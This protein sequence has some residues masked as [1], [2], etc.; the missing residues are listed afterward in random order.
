MAL[1]LKIDINGERSTK[2]RFPMNYTVQETLKDIWTSKI[3]K[4]EKD[5][6]L[7]LPKEGNRKGKAMWLKT[8]RTLRY[9]DLHDGDTIVYK[10]KHR[11]FRY[12]LVDGSQ[13]SVLIDDSDEVDKICQ[14]IAEHI[15]LKN[16]LE[17]GLRYLGDKTGWL[18]KNLTLHAQDVSEDPLLVLLFAREFFGEPLD[19]NDPFQLQ[20]NYVQATNA[21]VEGDYPCTRK[22]AVLFAAL[23][24]QVTFGNHD[25]QKHVVGWLPKDTFLPLKWRK[26]KAIEE[27]II[28]EHKKLYGMNAQA[29]KYRYYQAMR[30]LRSFGISFF[31]GKEIYQI[32]DK[33]NKGKQKTKNRDIKLGVSRYEIVL[34]EAETNEFIHQFDLEKLKAYYPLQGVL[35]LD[36]GDHY[37][38]IITISTESKAYA[39]RVVQLISGYIDLI[40][41]VRQDVAKKVEDDDDDLAA[42]EEQDA[43]WM[44]PQQAAVTGS[45][46]GYAQPGM[47][48]MPYGFLPRS[49]QVKVVD[50]NSAMKATKFLANELGTKKANWQNKGNLS[51]EQAQNQFMNDKKALAA[52]V[53]EL[54]AAVRL[55]PRGI[56]RHDMDIRAQQLASQ[57]LSIGAG[58]RALAEFDGSPIL[59]GAKAVA[60]ALVDMLNLVNHVLEH[61]DDIGSI[62][63]LGE[64]EKAM[65]AAQLLFETGDPS[66]IADGGS[67]QLMGTAISELDQNMKNLIENISL[68][69]T[70]VPDQIT[71]D[72]LALELKKYE[73]TKPWLI[74]TM[75]QLMPVILDPKM[76]EEVKRARMG[77]KDLT[78]HLVSK[79]LAVIQLNNLGDSYTNDLNDA[80]KAVNDALAHLFEATK[81]AEPKTIE[82]NLDFATPASMLTN[83]LAQLRVALANPESLV[84]QKVEIAQGP[85]VITVAKLLE[86]T[87]DMEKSDK[88]GLTADGASVSSD[89]KSIAIDMLQKFIKAEAKP[90]TTLR[91][92]PL[93]QYVKQSARAANG[94]VAVVKSIAKDADSETS[95]RLVK[96]GQ[97]LSDGI[98]ELLEE[99]RV[100]FKDHTNPKLLA[101]VVTIVDNL[102]STTQLLITDAGQMS[103]LNDLRYAAK[104]LASNS[105]VTA[106]FARKAL[107]TIEDDAAKFN[108]QSAYRK[109]QPVITEYLTDIQLAAADTDDFAKQV[110]LLTSSRK[111]MPEFQLLVNSAKG[112]AKY[113]S[114]ENIKQD[115]TSEASKLHDSINHL[116]KAIIAVGEITGQ[117][118]I[119]EA[120]E[121]FDSVKADLDTAEFAAA[122]GLL[123]PIP[124]QTRENALELLTAGV[125]TLLKAIEDLTDAAGKGEKLPEHISASAAGIAQ[126]AAAV[127]AVA[128]TVTDRSAQRRIIA[129]GQSV[130]LETLNVISVSLCSLLTIP[131]HRRLTT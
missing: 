109:I 40:L 46:G 130:N 52:A 5:H 124:G 15:G 25:P 1:E 67:K 77:V 35:K 62:I 22:E 88:K 127:R 74:K 114:D 18:D 58:A 122:H 73:A 34:L 47:P 113:I 126:V 11:V 53:N 70:S 90:P 91:T 72:R 71:K 3:G 129:A 101:R 108:L 120:L 48:F 89:G 45:V 110:D 37:H 10:K 104:I 57:M 28:V 64:A 54:L 27:D 24:A 32:E 8:E 23:Q 41:A 7:F 103:A 102:E 42:V 55:D 82:G 125:K 100:L 66:V 61:P 44:L 85:D 83:S 80:A 131:I 9:Y 98:K 93:I 30:A 39:D 69:I 19:Q 17:F 33:K 115:L 92:D 78:D 81:T 111:R 31:D 4:S 97:Q 95:E 12:A 68:L 99:S 107:P 51:K 21:I 49:N 128:S 43:N 76:A 60:D 87:A 94:V 59:D 79:V 96:T 56:Q 105:I 86:F 20:L 75:T 117:A 50:L 118:T 6:G 14:T 29:A 119:E 38:D 65:A 63:A 121:D 16:H 84:E 13:K 26:E 36:F 116:M 2:M 112:G 123:Q 106:S